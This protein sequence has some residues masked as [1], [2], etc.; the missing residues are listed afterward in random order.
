MKA[1]NVYLADANY[2]HRGT[3]HHYRRHSMSACGEYQDGCQSCR[4]HSR[5]SGRL[6]PFLIALP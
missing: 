5:V 4:M 6:L 1:T 2:L 3:L